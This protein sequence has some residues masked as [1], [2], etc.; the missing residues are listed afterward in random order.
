MQLSRRDSA[1]PRPAPYPSTICP[2]PFHLSLGV[3]Y[4]T[5]NPK[6]EALG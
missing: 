3:F 5:V 4:D 2:P 1:I 6:D